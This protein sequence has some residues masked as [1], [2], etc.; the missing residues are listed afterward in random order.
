MENNNSKSF[1][2]KFD[3]LTPENQRYILAIQQALIFA[4]S[5]EYD[6]KYVLE[7]QVHFSEKGAKGKKKTK[8]VT[9]V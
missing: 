5:Q 8:A 7:H 1:D 3:K 6:K 2:N 9:V 4:Q